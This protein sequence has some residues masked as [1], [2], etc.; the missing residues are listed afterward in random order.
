MA[1]GDGAGEEG[2]DLGLGAAEA[3]GVGRGD[4]E[5]DVDAAGSPCAHAEAAVGTARERQDRLGPLLTGEADAVTGEREGDRA[6]DDAAVRE[7]HGQAAPHHAA[8]GEGDAGERPRERAAE[9]IRQGAE[10]CL[11]SDLGKAEGKRAQDV[12]QAAT[13]QGD[14]DEGGRERAAEPVAEPPRL[15]ELLTQIGDVGVDADGEG[16]GGVV[17]P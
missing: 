11:E 3:F 10:G 9:R 13:A 1:L 4:V 12:A 17:G 7:G 6:R 16:G 14:V 5:G 8:A 15:G 2:G